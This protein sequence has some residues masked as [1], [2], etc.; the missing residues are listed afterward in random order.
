M[1]PAYLKLA[2]ATVKYGVT[3]FY[4]FL[5]TLRE[6]FAYSGEEIER[7]NEGLRAAWQQLRDGKEIEARPVWL[8]PEDRESLADYVDWVH[9]D[10]LASGAVKINAKG[11]ADREQVINAVWDDSEANRT[12]D[13]QR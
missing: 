6:E 4:G 5:R 10:V 9:E 1:L 3:S 2:R 11:E 8:E 7:D 12:R 13:L